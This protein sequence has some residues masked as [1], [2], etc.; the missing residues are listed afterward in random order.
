LVGIVDVARRAKVSA[1]TVSRV[2]NDDPRIPPPTQKRVRQAAAELGYIPNFAA[3]SLRLARTGTIGVVTADLHNPSH[4]E[5]LQELADGIARRG[6]MML[7]C[8]SRN[9]PAVEEANL[10]RLYERRVEGLVLIA[11]GS[12]SP[13]LTPFS[14]AGV[15][16]AVFYHTAS[17]AGLEA[18]DHVTKPL[19]AG[20]EHLRSLGHRRVGLLVASFPPYS[21]RLAEFDQLRAELGLDCDPG[22]AAVCASRGDVAASTL[23][24][25]HQPNPPTALFSGYHA[26]TPYALG[27][28]RTAGLRIPADLSVVTMGDSPWARAYV[29]PLTAMSV[30]HESTG[31]TAME[32]LFASLAGEGEPT[33]H[34]PAR[35]VVEYALVVRESTAPPSSTR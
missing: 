27:T 25:L 21:A 33:E 3:R 4:H 12:D 5:A 1:A 2:L 20:L 15:P 8:D 28:L 7:L 34:E 10:L 35:A 26:F 29:P 16:T 30:D 13:G 9:D 31:A 17:D 6:Y 19:Y 11:V 23:A 18:G 32:H 22:L 14:R 24:L